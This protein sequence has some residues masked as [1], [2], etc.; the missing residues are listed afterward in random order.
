MIIPAKR[1]NEIE[2][3]LLYSD[4]LFDKIVRLH[5]DLLNGKEELLEFQINI[6]F[7][8]ELMYSC[9]DYLAMDLWELY[10]SEIPHFNVHFPFVTYEQNEEMIKSEGRLVKIIKDK[11]GEKASRDLNLVHKLR[12][13][14]YVFHLNHN[15][16]VSDFKELRNHNSHK[17]LT[18][19]TEKTDSNRIVHTPQGCQLIFMG[20][21]SGIWNG[22]S[23]STQEDLQNYFDLPVSKEV[24]KYYVFPDITEINRNVIEFIKLIKREVG[25]LTEDLY[26]FIENDTHEKS[27]NSCEK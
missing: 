12:N 8:L 3:M 9:L 18:L 15:I 10:G 5:S 6:K 13:Y 4:G 2:A 19:Y 11:I 17:N 22:A 20:E 21:N 27:Q 14:Q 26:D 25:K 24:V 23:I 16:W 1:K 7:F